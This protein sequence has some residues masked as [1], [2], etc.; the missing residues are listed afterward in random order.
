MVKSFLGNLFGSS[1][2]SALGSIGF[3]ALGSMMNYNYSKRLQENQYSLNIKGLKESPTAQRQGLEI[4]GYNPILAVNSS[5]M[6]NATAG[7]GASV[8][9]NGLGSNYASISNARRLQKQEQSKL[10]ADTK[11]AIA[12]AN[13]QN[14]SAS[15]AQEQA[16]TEQYRQKEMESQTFLNNVN[17]ELARKDL[18]WRDKQYLMQ[19]KTGYLN[20]QANHIASESAQ[21]NAHTA[22][23]DYR[24][25]KGITDYENVQRKAVSDFYKKHP[26]QKSITTGLGEWTGAVG[27]IFSG[28]KKF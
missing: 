23:A 21:L 26:I 9:D 2:P 24:L 5:G 3:S 18:S 10:T 27:K 7:A 1:G 8:S 20:A 16:K 6:S 22:Q 19:I 17:T 28:S 4:A 14:A 15:L 12:G 11:N 25:R 13:S